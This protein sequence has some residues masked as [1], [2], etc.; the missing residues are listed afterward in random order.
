MS[1]S[2]HFLGET[3]IAD[4]G[5]RIDEQGSRRALLLVAGLAI[6]AGRPIERSELAYRLWPDSSDSQALTNLRKVLHEVRR[7]LDDEWIEVDQRRIRLRTENVDVDIERFLQAVERGDDADAV[8]VYGGPLLPGSWDDWLLDAR[9]DLESLAIQALHRLLDVTENV[10]ER[11][12]LAQRLLH[13]DRLDEVAHRMVIRANGELGNRAAA[14]RAFHSC[15]TVLDRELG[16]SPSDET[17]VEYEAVRADPAF[18]S[19]VARSSDRRRVGPALI[20]RDGDVEWLRRSWTD[21]T[22]GEGRPRGVVVAGESGI[23]KTRFVEELASDLERSGIAVLRTRA[24]ESD[25]GRALAPVVDWLRHPRTVT[26]IGGLAAHHRDELRR[27]LPEIGALPE[28]G[29]PDPAEAR[30]RLFHAVSAALGA[31]GEPMLLVLDDL[32]WCGADTIDLL[33]YLLRRGHARRLVVAMTHRDHERP[34]DRGLERKLAGLRADALLD[35]RHL[36]RLQPVH[37]ASIARGVTDHEWTDADLAQ[38]HI[39][40]DG[41][42]LFVVEAAR[43]G[44]GGDRLTSTV[45]GV[46]ERRLLQLADEQRRLLDVAAVFGRRFGPEELALATGAEEDEVID[47]LDDLWNVGLVVADGVEF[48]F[49]HDQFRDVV[50]AGISP[51]RCTNLHRQVADALRV[52]AGGTTPAIAG[53]LAEHL[54][55]AGM[56]DDAIDALVLSAQR[57]VTLGAYPHAIEQLRRGLGLVVRLGDVGLQEERELQLLTELGTAYAVEV[58]YGGSETQRT[59]QRAAALSRRMGVTPSGPVLRGLA[60]AAVSDCR[61]EQAVDLGD[62]LCRLEDPVARVE[63]DY[64]LGVTRFWQGRFEESERHLLRSIDAYDPAAAATHL[65]LYGQDPKA[66]CLC[67][68][69]YLRVVQGRAI[70][71]DTVLAEAVALAA[72]LDHGLT[73]WYVWSY[74]RSIDRAVGRR[75]SHPPPEKP[76]QGFFEATDH[77]G[78]LYDRALDGD[79][80]ADRRLEDITDQWR[81]EGHRLQLPE[82]LLAL[83]EV[84]LRRADADG[85]LQFLD[86]VTAFTDACGQH[87]VASEILRLRAVALRLRGDESA[88]TVARRA[89]AAA[90][91]LGAGGDLL[92]ARTELLRCTGDDEAA[93][94]LRDDLDRLRPVHHGIGLAEAEAELARCSAAG[95]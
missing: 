73:Q 58:G 20:G 41:H 36:G 29:V 62:A 31:V 1:R 3:R 37:T 13:L 61:F 4:G 71:A 59:W 54:E 63:G 83:A 18:G 74:S 80:D 5:R 57:A 67:R 94:A 95:E 43:G 92:R 70:E 79:V 91:G 14:I 40:T 84:R 12:A 42:P 39:E 17:V 25:A 53:R 46:I 50:L 27:L 82:W 2:I 66:V 86:E 38:L 75:C 6:D 45:K 69:A 26:A 89:V 44:P 22:A 52:R 32:Q 28:P 23:G 60:L 15:R 30:A 88:G 49:G 48:D 81:R 56:F 55:R 16:V 11:L 76:P 24:Y 77:D 87:Y 68:L 93:A 51:A 7:W 35:D 33:E 47:L 10:S 65:L 9:R 78:T 85:A 90:E 72:D 21:A 19:M 8:A 34:V 64:V